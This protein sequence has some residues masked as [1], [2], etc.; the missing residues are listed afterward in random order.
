MVG[1]CES[2]KD[3]LKDEFEKDYFKKLIIF[4]K[5]EYEKKIVYPEKKNI[6]RAFDLC[7]FND[8]K[9]VIL[10]QDP[11]PGEG[12]ANGLCFSVNNGVKTPG[13]LRNIFKEV[14]NDIGYVDWKNTNLDRWARQ[15]VLLLNTTLT[16]RANEP[17][18]HFGKGWEIFTNAVIERLIC[19]KKNVVYLLWG[20]KALEKKSIIDV[21]KNCVL[22][23]VH[24]S[25]LSAYNGFF[26]NNHFSRANKYLVNFGIK[27]IDWR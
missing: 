17:G 4:V 10:G 19:F 7:N 6:F 12:E 8:V 18:S 16:V 1:D 5:E 14:E 23:S 3:F 11:Y 15:G 21:E 2:W 22:T 13:S 25:P 24:P 20:R 27:E 26:H 9:V